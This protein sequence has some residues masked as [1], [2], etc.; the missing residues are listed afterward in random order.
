MGKTSG[1]TKG[2][3]PRPSEEE[4]D[5]RL[6]ELA[7]G[8]RARAK[9]NGGGKKPSNKSKPQPP[10]AP[11][12]DWEMDLILNAKTERHLPIHV[13]LALILRHDAQVS[14]CLAFDE[15]CCEPV[16]VTPLPMVNGFKREE[17]LLPRKLADYDT[18]H[19]EAWLQRN[20]CPSVG[21]QAV[22][23]AMVERAHESRFHPVRQWLHGL[24][25]D[26]VPRLSRLFVDYFGVK[27]D[28]GAKPDT[29]DGRFAAYVQTIGRMFI[30]ALVARVMK[31]GCKC[32]YMIVIEG[33]QGDQKSAACRIL[34]SEPWFSD[35]LPDIR[36]KEASQHLRGRW[37]IEMAELSAIRRADSETLKSFL[38]R[39]VEQYRPPF[40]HFEIDE[41]RQCVFI[42][43]TNQPTYLHDETG[44]RRFWPLKIGVIAL[45]ALARD[46]DQLF[47]EAVAAYLHGEQWWPDQAVEELLFK[48]EQDNR[49]EFDAWHGLIADYVRKFGDVYIIDIDRDALGLKNVE[50]AREVQHRIRGSLIK[51]GWT[52]GEHTKKGTPWSP[53]AADGGDQK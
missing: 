1:P 16:I 30:I 33:A 7:K 15:F 36:G 20:Y 24:Q 49:F 40:G 11:T 52:R 27:I 19:L 43:S 22:R 2:D 17:P 18:G 35:C 31:P 37:L 9:P 51:L 10:K 26:G 28:L 47:A 38:T 12:H 44:G 39:R 45:A 46:R 25:W 23:Q 5:A 48:P 32:D 6:G 3:G 42:G 29:S 13:N 4:V 34:A 8:L 21:A 41:P 14:S 50:V 53:K